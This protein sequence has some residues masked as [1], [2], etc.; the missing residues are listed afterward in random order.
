MRGMQGTAQ[1][2]AIVRFSS[3]SMRMGVAGIWLVPSRPDQRGHDRRKAGDRVVA[4]VVEFYIPS[5]FR[6]RVKWTPQQQRG[7]LIEFRPPAKKSA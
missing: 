7:K 4:N 1:K 5:R 2:V 3:L 6:K